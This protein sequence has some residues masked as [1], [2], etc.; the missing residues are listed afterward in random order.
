MS[1]FVVPR[2]HVAALVKFARARQVVGLAS[3]SRRAEMLSTCAAADLLLRDNW[4]S[5]CLRY[6]DELPETEPGFTFAEIMAAPILTPTEALKAANCLSYQCC[7]PP[8]WQERVAFT[9]LGLIER[10]AVAAGAQDRD[11]SEYDRARAWPV[12]GTEAA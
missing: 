5:Y 4:R 7:D 10:M 12:Y 2:V 3:L 6:P 9:L 8:D 1:A 11:S